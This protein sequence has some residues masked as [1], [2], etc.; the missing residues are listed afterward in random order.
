M[1]DEIVSKIKVNGNICFDNFL[2]KIPD[3]VNFK[4]KEWEESI[5]QITLPKEISD[6]EEYNKLLFDLKVK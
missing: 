4:D 6:L 1:Y 2:K 3:N 5:N